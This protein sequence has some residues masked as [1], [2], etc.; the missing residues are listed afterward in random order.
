MRDLSIVDRETSRIRWVKLDIDN[1]YAFREA[2]AFKAQFVVK[3][4][5]NHEEF[6]D[7]ICVM[8]RTRKLFK[9]IKASIYFVIFKHPSEMLNVCYV[10]A[11]IQAMTGRVPRLC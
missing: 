8:D 11:T 6:Y 3:R 9:Q 2:S 4:V 5:K 7:I 1:L 10:K